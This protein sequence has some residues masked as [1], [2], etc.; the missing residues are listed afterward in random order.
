MDDISLSQTGHTAIIT[1]AGRPAGRAIALA[2]S[3]AG[4]GVCAVDVNPDRLGK[5]IAMI[6][7]TG[8]QVMEWTG[9]ISNRFQVAAMIEAARDRCGPIDRVVTTATVDKRSPLLSIDEF[10]WRR[11]LEINLTGAFFCTQLA[12]RVMADEQGG[13]ILHVVDTLGTSRFAEHAAPRASSGAAIIGLTRQAARELAPHHIRINALAVTGLGNAPPA[14]PATPSPHSIGT[15]QQAARLALF[16]CSD[17]AERINGQVI[18][19]T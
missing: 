5:T 7:E 14:P 11:S 2:F 13:A 16:L 1:G 15:L 18:E 8:G 4:A 9:D 17:A 12:A 6:H 19:V 10:D 3:R